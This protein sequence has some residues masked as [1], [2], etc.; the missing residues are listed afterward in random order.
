MFFHLLVYAKQMISMFACFNCSK[1]KCQKDTYTLNVIKF[2]DHGL[3]REDRKTSKLC[4]VES[5][6]IKSIATS[7]Y[8]IDKSHESNQVLWLCWFWL[9]FNLR[10][11]WL[12][13]GHIYI[14]WHFCITCF[15]SK[16]RTFC[17]CKKYFQKSL[18]SAS[19]FLQM[20]SNLR[21]FKMT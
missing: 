8:E 20:T 6:T 4:M 14:P 10:V 11:L 16:S 18:A 1:S 17:C 15:S 9:W 7:T 13:L 2:I 5:S 19:K 3:P 21:N 12:H